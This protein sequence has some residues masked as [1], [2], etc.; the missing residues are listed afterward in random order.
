MIGFGAHYL[1][2]EIAIDGQE[3]VEAEWFT[4]DATPNFPA[5][6]MSIAGRLIDEWRARVG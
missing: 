5:G 2:G 6:G 3:I 4:A 1:S